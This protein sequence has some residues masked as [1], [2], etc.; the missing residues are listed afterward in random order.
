MYQKKFVLLCL[1][2]ISLS[3]LALAKAK[4]KIEPQLGSA[5]KS[6]AV[7][8]SPQQFF[9]MRMDNKE[10]SR[11]ESTNWEIIAT[12]SY[13]VYIGRPLGSKGIRYVEDLFRTDVRM[14]SALFGGYHTYQGYDVQKATYDAILP[15]LKRDYFK[16]LLPAYNWHSDAQLTPQGIK[17]VIYY[18]PL[19]SVR[20]KSRFEFEVLLDPNDLSI[21][22][23]KDL[24][25]AKKN[26]ERQSDQAST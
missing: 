15:N 6:K 9:D 21:L 8:I 23:I 7:M 13:Y 16:Y 20:K 4:I 14:L 17:S 11:L 2:M 19:Q 1:V 18:Q 10:H 5:E 25:T 24:S 12:D 3:T 22:S 26:K